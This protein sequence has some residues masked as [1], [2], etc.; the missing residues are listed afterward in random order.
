MRS[1]MRSDSD[2]E[3]G[4]ESDSEAEAVDGEAL[5]NPP[6]DARSESSAAEIAHRL[7]RG[8]RR[9]L[10]GDSELGDSL[11]TAGREPV[12]VMAK[13]LAEVKEGEASVLRELGLGALQLVQAFAPGNSTD[14]SGATEVAILFTDLVGF[15]SWALEAG[16]DAVLE[17]IREVAN[18]VEKRFTEHGGEIVKRLGDG[19]MVAFGSAEDAVNAALAAIGALEDCDLDGYEPKIRA[20]VHLGRPRKLGGDYLGVDVNIAARVADAARPEQVLVSEAALDALD[21]GVFKLGRRRR[22]KA[23]G[24]P[25]GFQVASAGP[26]AS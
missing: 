22:L 10:P 20:G 5:A 16:D 23:D 1:I 12:D 14:E 13:Q 9:F 6:T 18:L 4:A 21:E 11:S 26:R 15:S 19:H 17:G 3:S 2:P 8:T 25:K 24:I 7:I